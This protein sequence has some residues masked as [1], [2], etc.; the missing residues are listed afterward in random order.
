MKS[1]MPSTATT[2]SAVTGLLG[3]GAR[4]AALRSAVG[5]RGRIPSGTSASGTHKG[6]TTGDDPRRRYRTLLPGDAGRPRCGA[7]WGRPGGIPGKQGAPHEE[8][9]DGHDFGR[10]G[11]RSADSGGFRGRRCRVGSGAASPG[12]KERGMKKT[13]TATAS[14][15][16]EIPATGTGD[17]GGHECQGR[18][19]GFRPS[20][21]T[22]M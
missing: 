6:T 10:V 12:S 17:S 2:A 8:D 21:R 18:R 9:D 5:V 13:T 1:A 15:A 4:A 7:W 22:V 19:S 11:G 14:A 3:S 20:P 16:S